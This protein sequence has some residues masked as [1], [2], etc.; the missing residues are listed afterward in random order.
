MNLV[1][2]IYERISKKSLPLPNIINAL[3]IDDD[4]FDRNRFRRLCM[5]V[6]LTI[7]GADPDNYLR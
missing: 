5:E 3:M 6:G 2:P 1:A 7:K 4:Q